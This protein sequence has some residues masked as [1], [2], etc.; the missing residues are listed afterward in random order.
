MLRNAEKLAF[1][2]NPR[3]KQSQPLQVISSVCLEV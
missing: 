1:H 3:E 2:F